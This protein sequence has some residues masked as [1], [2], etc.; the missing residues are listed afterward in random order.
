MCVCVWGWVLES[1]APVSVID[2]SFRLGNVRSV[3][4][5]R[6]IKL[7]VW[8]L[9]NETVPKNTFLFLTTECLHV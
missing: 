7:D 2:L 9:W 4:W 1:R 6:F 8:I 3:N 5:K